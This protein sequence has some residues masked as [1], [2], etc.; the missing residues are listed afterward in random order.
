MRPR[1]VTV[2]LTK[3]QFQ[4]LDAKV[5]SAGFANRSDYVRAI[6]FMPLTFQEKIDKIYEKVVLNGD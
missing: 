1:C 6:L 2:R 3:E 5:R 4:I